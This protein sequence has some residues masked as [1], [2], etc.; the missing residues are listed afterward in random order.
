MALSLYILTAHLRPRSPINLQSTSI[1]LPTVCVCCGFT[2]DL[3]H[4]QLTRT[5]FN[6]WCNSVDFT[7]GDK[8]HIAS[9]S[10]SSD[11]NFRLSRDMRCNLSLAMPE[12]LCPKLS[13]VRRRWGG[14]AGDN[15]IFTQ[16]PD[17][18]FEHEFAPEDNHLDINGR[19]FGPTSIAQDLQHC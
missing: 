19:S 12:P 3:V 17:F 1:S 4:G 18:F 5:I 6:G 16:L 11:L 10:E 7:R 9:P 14:A 8:I 2:T 13:S 15:R